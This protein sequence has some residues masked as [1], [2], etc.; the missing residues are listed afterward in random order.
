MRIGRIVGVAAGLALLSSA[1]V[2]APVSAAPVTTVTN[3]K[4]RAHAELDADWACDNTGA[5]VNVGGTLTLENGP[6][7]QFTFKNNAKGT[8]TFL[9]DPDSFPVA[10]WSLTIND[11][12]GI[13]VPKQ[14]A[15]TLDASSGVTGTGTGGN[16][17]ISFQAVDSNGAVLGAPIL[18]GRCVQGTSFKHVSADWQLP[19][20]ATVTT[21]GL[22]C[23]NARSELSFGG[24]GAHVGVDGLLYLD[25]NIN[26]VVHRA[27]T[28]A[29]LGV[30]LFGS[31][32]IP[33]SPGRAGGAGGNPHI[34][35]Q[36]YN[37]GGTQLSDT[38]LGRCRSL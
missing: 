13:T 20:S 27:T 33:K 11:G 37:T 23:T 14:P 36:V 6:T 12:D 22:S 5:T 7:V 18:L 17:Y 15:R 24:N 30:S 35:L 31:E 25:N 4:I 1:G 19:A 28:T 2:I 3:F 34:S 16:P 10:G 8:H 9:G 38:Y 32:M 26:K 21:A 29:N